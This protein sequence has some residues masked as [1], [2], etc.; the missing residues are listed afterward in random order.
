MS[1]GLFLLDAVIR[2]N[3]RGHFRSLHEGLFLDAEKPAFR[4]VATHYRRH[5]VLPSSPVMLDAAFVL[6][7]GDQ[8][9]GYY[10]ER[11]IDRAAYNT[12]VAQQLATAAAMQSRDMRTIREIYTSTARTLNTIA[13]QQ[14]VS[15]LADLSAGVM[16]DYEHAHT[17]PGMQGVTLGWNILD[18]L[19]G[20]GEGGDVITFAA[21]PGFGKSWLLSHIALQAWLSGTSV[22]FVSMEMTGKQIVRRLLA[23]YAGIN[24]DYIR[25]GAMSDYNRDMIYQRIDELRAGVPFHLLTGSF[26]KSVPLVDAAIQEFSPGLVCIDASYLMAP[27][28]SGQRPAFELVGDVAKEIKHV[29]TARNKPIVQTVQFNREAT[30]AKRRGAQHIGGSDAV[31]QITTIGVAISEGTTPGCEGTRRTL[32]LFK[33]REGQSEASFEIEFLFSPPSFNHIPHGAEDPGA[34]GHEPDAFDVAGGL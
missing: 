15:S 29:A 19:T 17:H 34:L 31:G 28:N 9:V 4:F 11:C 16:E 2:N 7:H 10:M 6:P 23:M 27:A 5:G 33:N 20:G 14:D 3:A 1:Q 30:K 13:T 21:R 22:L 8:P 25:R 26:D 24:P 12:V 18:E 32:E